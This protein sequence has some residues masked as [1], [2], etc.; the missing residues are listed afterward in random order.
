VAQNYHDYLNR[1]PNQ[2]EVN[3]WVDQF[4][5]HHFSNE[6]LIQGFVGSDENFGQ[7]GSNINCWLF[8]AYP[9][10][11]HRDPDVG[12]YGALLVSL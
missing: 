12:G 10:V 2:A 4:V 11:L 9:E 6:E 8:Y 5:N 7:H 1:T 3:Y